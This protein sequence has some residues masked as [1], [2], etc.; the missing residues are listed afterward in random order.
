MSNEEMRKLLEKVHQNIT[1]FDYNDSKV[2]CIVLPEQRY[3]EIMKQ[4]AGKPVSVD[5]N[6][7]ILQ[8][9]LGH[10]FVEITLTFSLGDITEKIMLYANNSLD[11]FESLAKTSMLALSSSSDTGNE[12]IFMIQLP[13]PEKAVNALEIIKKGLQSK[14]NSQN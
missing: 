11:F 3:L 13:K 8:D 9:G 2:P 6:L 1:S 14:P 7:N 10:V 5:T 4:V 12:N